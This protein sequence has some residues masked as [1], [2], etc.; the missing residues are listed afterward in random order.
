MVKTADLFS[1]QS[2]DFD[3]YIVESLD[4]IVLLTL[5]CHTD[6]MNAFQQPASQT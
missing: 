1:K 2:Q 5:P 4:E 3:L 6:A